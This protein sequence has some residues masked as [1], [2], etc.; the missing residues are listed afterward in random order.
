METP[1]QTIS[2]TKAL[3]E[4]IKTEGITDASGKVL[5]SP[6]SPPSGTQGI[7]E[8]T[9]DG[10]P[11]LNTNAGNI[12]ASIAGAT[13]QGQS[14]I[15]SLQK[16]LDELAKQQPTPEVQQEKKSIMDLISK[17]ETTVANQKST[18]ELRQ[19]ALT[20]AYKEMGVTPE[21]ISTIGSLIGEVTEYNKQIADLEG[22]KET[23]ITA[24]EG[25]PGIDVTNMGAE[26]N[27]ISK[28]Y[29]SEISAKSLQAGVKVQ[30]LQMIQGAYDNAKSTAKD[31]VELATYDQQQ[32]VADIE[33]ALG[34]HQDLY[35]LMTT[36]EKTQWDK[37]Y[38]IAKDALD[39]AKKTLTD[40]SQY[41][42]DPATADAFKGQ[43]WTK[44]TDVEFANTLAKY[45]SSQAYLNKQKQLALSGSVSGG[46]GTDTSNIDTWAN[47]LMTGQI[48]IQ[49]VPMALR[50]SVLGRVSELGGSVISITFAGKAKEAITAFNTADQMLNKIEQEVSNVI[51]AGSALGALWQRVSGNVGAA[52]KLNPDAAVYKD[53]VNAFLSQL[54]R[55]SGEKGVLTTQDVDRI[56]NA[57]PAF[58]DTKAIA[59]RKLQNL[60]DLFSAI[61]TGATQTYTQSLSKVQS[62][63]ADNDPLGIR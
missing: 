5:Q 7:R 20:Q 27:R 15:D 54:T 45:T 24:V 16:K 17:R 8:F 10:S 51:T 32:E 33:W 55:A 6:I 35:N 21:Q 13:T 31:I 47:S 2:N 3:L 44:L 23:A 48:G 4:R 9:T 56:K 29:N 28:A 40:R 30:E 62:T 37:Q 11:A 57:L 43:D 19:E 60:R 39:T 61:K 59:D 12:S 63:G 46:V 26:T 53:T 14:T 50:D 18:T 22:K 41:V 1:Q 34:A 52:T 42:T 38:T 25:R 49:N 36:E 58:S